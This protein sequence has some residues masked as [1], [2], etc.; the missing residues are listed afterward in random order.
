MV[1]LKKSFH[2]LASAVSFDNSRFAVA[3]LG[4]LGSCLCSAYNDF[5]VCVWLSLWTRAFLARRWLFAVSVLGNLRAI[6]RRFVFFRLFGVCF[7]RRYVMVLRVPCLR[8]DVV[9]CW[10]I[11]PTNCSVFTKVL[12]SCVLCEHSF[13]EEG[14]CAYPFH[15][16]PVA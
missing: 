14:L 1:K 12:G 16:A 10:R 3:Y 11:R 13:G 15:R 9:P 7:V 5:T 4:L 2:R 8:S 6:S